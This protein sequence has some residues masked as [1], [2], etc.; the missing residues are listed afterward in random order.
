M[1]LVAFFLFLIGLTACNSDQGADLSAGPVPEPAIDL[2]EK[3]QGS[4]SRGTISA[5]VISSGCTRGEHFSVTH[6]VR[7][8]NLCLL[9]IKR[10]TPDFCKRAAFAQNIKIS[11]P[12]AEDCQG[13]Q[14]EF[15]NPPLTQD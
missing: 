5:Q 15:A 13:L 4:Y 11:W 10:D 14:V 7:D 9:T 3:L 12:L 6:Q 1:K 2:L 8:N